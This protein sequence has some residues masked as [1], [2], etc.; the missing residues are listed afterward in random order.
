MDG[1][2]LPGGL[3]VYLLFDS[4][5]VSYFLRITGGE[6]GGQILLFL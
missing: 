3:E 2:R 6:K 4:D 5:V 1:D